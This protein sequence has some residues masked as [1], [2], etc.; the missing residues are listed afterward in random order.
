MTLLLAGVDRAAFVTALGARL[1][2]VGVPVDLPSVVALS[3]ALELAFPRDVDALYWTARVTLVHRHDDLAA[4]DRLFAAAFRDAAL[5]VDP[6]SR[7]SSPRSEVSP[8]GET[9]APTAGRPGAASEG[10]G[11]PWHTRP[12]VRPA[13]LDEPDGTALPELRASDLAAL[14][15]TPLDALDEEELARLQAWLERVA[16]RWPTRRSRRSAPTRHGRRVALRDTLAASRRT[17]WEPVRLHHRSPRRR[18][19]PVTVVLDLSRSMQPYSTAYLHLLRVLARSGRAEVFAFSTGLTR[20][21]PVLAHRCMEVALERAEVHLEDRFGGTR[22][23]SS[24][25]ELRRS[26]HGNALRGGVLVI[27]SDGWDA[28]PPEELARELA[29]L[30]RRTHRIVWLNPR[31]AAPGF[32]PLVGPMAAALPYCDVF[33]SAH[34]PHALL[35]AME[36]IAAP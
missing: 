3:D 32:E 34:S 25:R 33:L 7:R 8:P 27:A 31:S 19:R 4:F 13:D 6:A 18:P 24:L 36:A 12:R 11:L 1:R 14:A 20:L 9:W 5:P 26:R 23:A 10:D 28:D 22:L 16:T 29:R 17:G 15:D 21:T 2:R 35:E 30:R